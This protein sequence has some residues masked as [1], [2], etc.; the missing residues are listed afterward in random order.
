MIA[1]NAHLALAN[2]LFDTRAIVQRAFDLDAILLAFDRP[3]IEL[4]PKH[5]GNDLRAGVHIADAAPDDERF[6][7]QA[8]N[9]PV[10][11]LPPIEWAW[12]KVC[13]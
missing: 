8:D 4:L 10:P 11:P 3:R 13:E 6:R 9:E 12:N 2:H 7:N 5:I 1:Q